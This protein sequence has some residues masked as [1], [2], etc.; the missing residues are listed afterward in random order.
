[1]S[2]LGVNDD[3]IRFAVVGDQSIVDVLVEYG[4]NADDCQL[5][6]PQVFAVLH[7]L[8]HERVQHYQGDYYH[9]ALWIE[10]HVPAHVGRG[11]TFSFYYG[12][13][14]TGTSIGDDFALVAI[15]NEHVWEVQITCKDRRGNGGFSHYLSIREAKAPGRRTIKVV[16]HG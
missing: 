2:M 16:P 9:D 5:A 15:G 13:R 11:V 8:T 4:G 10:R 14:D 12:A 6:K 1:M 3:N 7:Q